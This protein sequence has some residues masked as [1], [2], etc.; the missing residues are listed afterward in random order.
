MKSVILALVATVGMSAV[1]GEL[2]TY[3][4]VAT[5][6]GL[7]SPDQITV[8]ASAD[9]LVFSFPGWSASEYAQPVA[10]RVEGA[11]DNGGAVYDLKKNE[12]E[13][14]VG[15]NAYQYNVTKIRVSNGIM[16]Q[17]DS[18]VMTIWYDAVGSASGSWDRDYA[19]TERK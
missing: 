2:N 7:V 4:C 12:K 14:L 11:G 5:G 15:I 3:D 6:K 18:G 19:C 1:A 8:Q 17:Q 16:R 13:F 9:A 10:E